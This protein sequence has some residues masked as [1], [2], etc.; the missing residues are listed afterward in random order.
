M[1][2][3]FMFCGW[4]KLLQL[5]VVLLFL[6]LLGQA[7]SANVVISQVY[8][9]GGNTGAIYNQ[10]FVELFNRSASPVTITGWTIQYAS[11]AGAFGTS[12]NT[13]I[14]TNATIPAGG[15]YLVA[16]GTT[17]AAGTGFTADQ[18][19]AG[20][21]AIGSGFAAAAG[22]IALANN[23]TT[24]TY[25]TPNAFSANVVDAVGYGSGVDA[26]EG[27]A[28]AVA[29][30]V[31]ASISRTNAGCTDT[32]N[33]SADFS[34]TSFGAYPLASPRG[35]GAAANTCTSPVLVAN[36][37][38]LTFA[39][40]TG[41]SAATATYTLAG[42]NLTANAP[43]A[44][45]SSDAAVLVS[46]TGAA[47]S[48]ATTASV[49][50]TASGTLMQAITV[51]F[52]ASATAGTTT[53]TISNS[54][55][56]RTASVA[57]TGA[58][59]TAYTWNGSSTSFS[60]PT[61]W[62]PARTT[63]GNSDVL[64]FNGANTPI[65]TVVLDYTT[66]QTVG[67]L[68][69]IN[70]VAATLSTDGDRML[71]VDN[72]LPGDDFVVR[73]G[74]AVTIANSTSAGSSGLTISLTSTETAAIGGT[75]IFTGYPMT[76]NGRHVLQA[77]GTS[78]IQFL[79]GSIFRTTTGYSSTSPFGASTT[80]N[81]SVVFRNGARCE[82]YGGTSP[83]GTST[84][85]VVILESGS[86]F[87]FGISG[88]FPSL[89][90]R[91]YGTLA[92]DVGGTSTASNMSGQLAI[93]GDLLILNG[94][95]SIGGTGSITVLGNTQVANAASF[96]LATTGASALQ[97]NVQVNSTA[98]LSFAPASAATVQLNGTASQTLGGSSTAATP[99]VFNAN[100]TLQI[101]NAAGVTLGLPITIPGTLQ[102]TNGL[103]T[104]TTANSLTLA[105]NAQGGSNTSF[106]SGPVL[107]PVSTTGSY[108]FPIGKSVSF[109]PLTLNVNAQNG[110]TYYRAEQ[111]EGN[112]GQNVGS[113]GLT[114]VSIFRSFTITP[115]ASAADAAAGTVTQPGAFM[116]TATLSFGSND[117]VTNPSQLVVAKR[118]NSSS[119]W[120]NQGY[121]TSTG[122]AASGTVTSGTFNTFSDFALGSTSTDPTVNPLPVTL[123]NFEATRQTS[124]PVQVRW[125]TA[126]EQHSAYF[127]VQRS[128][129]GSTFATVAKVAANGTTTQAHTY[130]SLDQSAPVV[131]LYYRLR[132]VDTGGPET[133]SPVVMLAATKAAATLSLYPSPAHDYLT[134]P[135]T[136]GE[137]VQVIDL[138]GRVLQ[139][140]KLPTSGQLSVETLPAGTYLLRVLLGGQQHI[141]R[142]TKD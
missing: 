16:I 136:A 8:A 34:T 7:Q 122:A 128:L 89:A 106:V 24:V 52:T 48:F 76:A 114:R 64:L 61:S 59:I 99:I 97:G 66:T 37:A 1:K 28:R 23:T 71:V 132:Q 141:V 49:T 38:A 29:P 107:R 125:A 51:Q 105:A 100:T 30:T 113:S 25:T 111:F 123:T 93:Q 2:R 3:T 55:S 110:T 98:T 72:N 73:A 75:L 101:N 95:V 78:A 26:Y 96:A 92:Y 118:P 133:F 31:T 32:N 90:G 87:L 10:D 20:V 131:K 67:Q 124:G 54:G 115:F 134:V 84:T 117:G 46:T 130:T 18:P 126:S 21:T 129:D 42:F 60:S 137:E 120:A 109:R 6:P 11:A 56:M 79:E 85:S 74:S 83:F 50:T 39:A 81:N 70:N 15:Y 86:Y 22:K 116:G 40:P 77:A 103:L 91:T 112:P 19:G 135:A 94:N 139:T 62:T 36:P 57:V 102:L 119:A 41:Q 82:Q 27:A 44:I 127:E 4:S 104:T 140:T 108:I 53:A 68:Y 63:P 80:N 65:P 142:F 121:T 69:F 17:G 33:N 43:I 5:F 9:A 12:T 47:G 14:L 45:S 58:S 138:A 35:T 88:T 13:Y